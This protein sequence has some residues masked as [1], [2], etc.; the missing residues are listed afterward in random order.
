M[1]QAN[2]SALAL[3]FAGR[4]EPKPLPFDPTKLSGLSERLI[5]SHWENNHCGALKALNVIEQRLAAMLDDP[6][7]PPYVYGDLSSRSTST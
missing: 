1:A 5:R 3:S 7:L 4:H 6:D 2:P